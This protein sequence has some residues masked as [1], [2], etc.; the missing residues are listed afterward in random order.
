M[1]IAL[2]IKQH[3]F[4]TLLHESRRGASNSQQ[5]HFM[6]WPSWPSGSAVDWTSKT[7]QFGVPKNTSTTKHQTV[8]Y[9]LEG[10]RPKHS[11]R[12]FSRNYWC[13]EY[14]R[15]LHVK[16]IERLHQ[17][18]GL[19]VGSE[20]VQEGLV[21]PGPC[22]AWEVFIAFGLWQSEHSTERETRNYM[23]EGS[24]VA[25]ICNLGS[26]VYILPATTRCR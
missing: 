21:S 8:Q 12:S 23:P 9:S 26:V 25:I 7:T 16:D 22:S 4:W 14:A 19:R 5:A 17:I 2:I 20:S 3:S 1:I 10:R 13:D 15:L 11:S 18:N 6:R 24:F